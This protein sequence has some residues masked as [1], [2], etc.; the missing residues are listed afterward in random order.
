[1]TSDQI[2]LPTI[3][4]IKKWYRRLPDK[5]RYLEF[6][7]AFLTIPVLLTVLLNNISNIQ[8]QQVMPSPTP[9]PTE[10]ITKNVTPTKIVTITATVSATPTPASECLKQIGP[11]EIVYP[12]ENDSL[13]ANPICLDIVRQTNQYCGVV[14]SYRIN[15][16]GWSA[17]TDKSICM[18][19]LEPGVKNLELR[20]KSII[21]SDEIILK[22]TFTAAGPTPTPATQSATV[23]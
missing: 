11:I 17:Y 14:W 12:E 15:G 7:T 9:A 5:K 6:I 4:R 8:K 3:E 22:R 2:E 10:A 20:V 23:H 19:G 1:M 16:S 18:Y 13:N 21:S